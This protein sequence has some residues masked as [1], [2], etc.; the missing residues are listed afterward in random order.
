MP[1]GGKRPGAGRKPG[2]LPSL[3][4]QSRERALASGE[5]PHEFLLRVARGIDEF[6]DSAVKDGV[7]VTI[8]RRPTFAERVDAAKAAASYFQPRL[9]QAD[10]THSGHV[11][12]EQVAA[13]VPREQSIAASK[14]I[15]RDAGY[16]IDD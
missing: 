13:S 6:E 11:T 4:K 14:E 8:R 10:V 15:L 5:L 1:R 9:A 7:C 3:A 16:E 12:L 2:V